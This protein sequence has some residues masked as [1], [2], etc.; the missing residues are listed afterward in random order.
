MRTLAVCA[1]LAV[2][3]SPVVYGQLFGGS[4]KKESKEE[5]SKRSIEG[6]VMSPEETPAEGAIV[7][8]KD[9]KSL[10]VRSFV[11]KADGKYHFF[12]LSINN[13][14]EVKAELQG[15]ISKVRNLSVFDARKKAT[16]DLKL[17][18]VEK[19]AEKKQ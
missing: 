18:K 6:V 2:A 14:Y 1:F 12:G 19:A 11:T 13:D 10:Q 8:L 3:S 16:M 7:Q 9:L 4:P 15:S 17:E 5:A